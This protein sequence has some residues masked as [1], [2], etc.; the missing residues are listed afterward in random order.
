[1]TYESHVIV[2]PVQCGTFFLFSKRGKL[3]VNARKSCTVSKNTGKTYRKNLQVEVL[4]CA[5]HMGKH[6]GLPV[7]M[8]MLYILMLLQ[9]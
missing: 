8:A 3:K 2:F 7:E 9:K 6:F 4:I 5:R 1:M